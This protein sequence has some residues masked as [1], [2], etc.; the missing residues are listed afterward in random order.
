MEENVRQ[1]LE[2]MENIVLNW[3]RVYL[4]DATA[5]GNNDFLV[6]IRGRNYYLRQPIPPP[7]IP[8]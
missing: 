3:K 4:G 5:D 7:V 8:V 2:A 1:E 6:E